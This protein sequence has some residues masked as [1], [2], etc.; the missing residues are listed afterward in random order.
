[1]KT[2]FKTDKKKENKNKDADEKKEFSQKERLN[3]VM[4]QYDF[5]II[6]QHK[7]MVIT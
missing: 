3:T 6:I 5:L 1:M 7:Y 2:N 4:Y